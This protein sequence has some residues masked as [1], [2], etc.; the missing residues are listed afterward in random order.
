MNKLQTIASRI[1]YLSSRLSWSRSACA[2][3]PLARQLRD[4]AGHGKEAQTNAQPRDV[5]L[6]LGS[7]APRLSLPALVPPL[8]SNPPRPPARPLPPSPLVLLKRVAPPHPCTCPQSARA[9]PP[10]PP[11]VR[12]LQQRAL[13]RTCRSCTTGSPFSLPTSAGRFCRCRAARRPRPSAASPCLLPRPQP[14]KAATRKAGNA[15]RLSG[16][17]S[18]SAASRGARGD[19]PGGRPGGRGRRRSAGST[20]GGGGGR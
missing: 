8:L 10:A 5:S 7:L 14:A 4:A 1:P 3:R 13:S 17:A 19:S 12:S 6:S 2:P 18:S 11:P 20:A 9:A 16:P 15:L